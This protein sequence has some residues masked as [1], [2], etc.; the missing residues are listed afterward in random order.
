[1][2]V[3]LDASFLGAQRGGDETFLSGLLEGLARRRAPDD[4]FPLL[5]PTPVAPPSVAGDGA[6]PVV[7]L[8]RGPGPWHYAVGLPAALR[9]IGPLD[10]AVSVTHIPL[11]GSVPAALVLGDLSFVHRPQDY[12]PP[13]ARRL[14]TLVPRHLDRARAVLVPSEFTRADVLDT[15]GLDPELVHVVPNRVAPAV[16]PD[17]DD[18]ATAAETAALAAHGVRSP[19]LLYVGNLHPRKNVGRLVQAFLQARR[20]EPRLRGHR[21]VVAGAR[22][23]RGA[24]EERAAGGDADV[25]FLGRVS[26][27]ARTLL[28]TGAEA[29]AY[30]SLFEGFGL[31][32]LEAMAQGVPVLTSTVT[33]MPEVCGDA[34][35]YVDPTDQDAVSAGVR[36]ILDDDGLRRRLR[37]AGP[38]RAA[39]FDADR[40]GDAALGAFRAAT[41]ANPEGR[42]PYRRQ[43]TT[44]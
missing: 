12:P 10:L 1:V 11:T 43:R 26:D 20:E 5:L 21:L 38:A 25:V 39:L 2:R 7:P 13:T 40:V 16:V 35:L 28:L 8:R 6:F 27:T 23:F 14:R 34:A 22:W 15:Y 4:S 24:V 9:R 42:V 33:S 30:V 41:R 17:P 37:L 32:P 18:A 31:P 3:A 19:Y 36:R 44:G 29:L